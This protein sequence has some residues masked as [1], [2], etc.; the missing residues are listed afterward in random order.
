MTDNETISWGISS[1]RENAFVEHNFIKGKNFNPSSHRD[2]IDALVSC[3]RPKSTL[4]PI[5]EEAFGSRLMLHEH[6]HNVGQFI[7]HFNFPSRAF[8]LIF[9]IKNDI[10]FLFAARRRS[11][12]Q[13]CERKKIFPWHFYNL[14]YSTSAFLSK[15]NRGKICRVWWINSFIIILCKS[16]RARTRRVILKVLTAAQITFSH[17][18]PRRVKLK[19]FHRGGESIKNFITLRHTFRWSRCQGSVRRD[20]GSFDGSGMAR[21]V[22]FQYCYWISD[23]NYGDVL[24]VENIRAEQGYWLPDCC[25]LLLV[26]KFQN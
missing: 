15:E 19:N 26:E 11:S 7:A 22:S 1:S 25:W 16:S 6:T 9:H 10:F 14:I 21:F 13:L 23:T 18:A 12:L 4:Y 17:C 2:R 8:W 20:W 24:E 3:M 5:F